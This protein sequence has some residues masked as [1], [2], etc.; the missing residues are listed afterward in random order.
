M[1]RLAHTIFPERSVL[2]TSD[3]FTCPYC[4]HAWA[5]GT[6][7]ESSLRAGATTHTKA[8]WEIGLYLRGYALDMQSPKGWLAIPL[9]GARRS[10]IESI[11]RTVRKRKREGVLEMLLP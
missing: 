11:K 8:C 4:A 9:T 7:N 6:T 2:V 10:R 3:K 1:S 5:R